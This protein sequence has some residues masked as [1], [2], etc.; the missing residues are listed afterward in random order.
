M[1]CDCILPNLLVGP[2]PRDDEDFKTLRSL[3]VTAILSLQTEE[4]RK[5][6]GIEWERSVATEAGL[7]FGSVPV[8]DF[9]LADLKRKLPDCVLALDR[10]L[11]AGN[12]VYV[13]CTAGVSRSPTIAAAYLHW[14][15]AW[16]LE[17]ALAHV[18]T[19]RICCP[20][21]EAIRGARWPV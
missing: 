18:Q 6:D 13:H 1:K 2:D 14:C 12:T 4:D 15:L 3:K 8:T 11:K 16:P 9:D 7:T 20:S 5:E 19:A 10:M 17:Q 21:S